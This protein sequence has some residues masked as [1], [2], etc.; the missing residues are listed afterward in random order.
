MLKKLRE[1]YQRHGK[2]PFDPALWTLA[3]YRFGRWSEELPG[4]ARK[5]GSTIYNAMVLG[6][7]A[8]TGNAMYREVQC[9]EALTMPHS[10]NVMIHPEAIIGDRVTIEHGVSIASNRGREGA[11]VIGNDVVI[12]C[13]AKILGPV[14]IGDGAT[15][16]SNS[17]VVTD[18]PAGATAMGVP[19]RMRRS[20]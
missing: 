7:Q 2:D 11:P 14:K 4:P 3:A 5:V 15:I 18:V 1:D 8:L 6:V 20:A 19:A 12:Q 13:G 17:L 10:R 9:G 16:I